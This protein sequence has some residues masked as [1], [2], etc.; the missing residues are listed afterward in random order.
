MPSL[1]GKIRPFNGSISKFVGKL[2]C[3]FEQ[4]RFCSQRT[5]Q[6]DVHPANQFVVKTILVV[7]CDYLVEIQN[8]IR[9]KYII[10][11]LVCNSLGGE[12]VESNRPG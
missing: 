2:F 5:W 10:R 12:K 8:N 9:A 4:T 11:A 6:T 1:P 3:C 7:P